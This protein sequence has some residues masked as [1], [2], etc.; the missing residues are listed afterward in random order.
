MTGFELKQVPNGGYPSTWTLL[1]SNDNGETWTELAAPVALGGADDVKRR[2]IPMEAQL[3]Y[4]SHLLST[5]AGY[6]VTMGEVILYE[7]AGNTEQVS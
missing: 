4:Q 5:D 2:G 6:Y 7:A 1:G 3:P